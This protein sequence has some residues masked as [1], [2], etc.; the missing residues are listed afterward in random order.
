MGLS[1]LFADAPQETRTDIMRATYAALVEHG[2]AD[3]TIQRIADEF[4]KSKSLIY[5]H[6]DG[7]D[8]LLLDFMTFLVDRFEAE[9]DATSEADPRQRLDEFF[10]RLVPP[11]VEE[12]RCSFDQVMIE[13]RAAA[14]HDPAFREQY[15]ETDRVLRDKLAE[16][17]RA[18]MDSGEFREGDPVRIA[19]FLLASILGTMVGRATSDDDWGEDIR[20]ELDAHVA[21]RLE[22]Y[23]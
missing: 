11:T 17:L 2:Y 4:D 16:V 18:G 7:K 10:D 9:M 20:A 15:T 14:A 23:P 1:E 21:A 6:Y 12:D 8:A 19:G 5:H 13:L 3:L 22:P